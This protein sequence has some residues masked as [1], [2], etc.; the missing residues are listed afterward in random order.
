[1]SNEHV[2]LA[3]ILTLACFCAF[4]WFICDAEVEHRGD[5]ILDLRADNQRL[6]DRIQ[7]LEAT[8][9]ALSEANRHQLG[10]PVYDQ[11]AFARL[12]KELTEWEFG[13]A[14]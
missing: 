8:V 2:A 7:G 4:A 1:M 12:R 14:S 6:R 11:L 9:T 13:G 5:R 3:I 10:E